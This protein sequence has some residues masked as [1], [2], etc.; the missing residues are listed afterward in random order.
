MSP[1]AL[2]QRSVGPVSGRSGS[3]ALLAP[4][5]LVLSLTTACPRQTSRLVPEEVTLAGGEVVR[6]HHPNLADHGGVFVRVGDRAANGVVIEDRDLLRIRLP[7]S[8]RAGPVTVSLE[9]ADGT[10]VEIVDGLEYQPG[11]V[12]VAR[13]EQGR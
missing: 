9:F 1:I 2:G 12:A 5:R 3:L 11:I 8:D 4:A 10:R 7:S 13:E 6:L